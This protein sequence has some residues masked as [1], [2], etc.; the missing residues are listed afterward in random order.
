MKRNTKFIIGMATALAATGILAGCGTKKYKITFVSNGS[1]LVPTIE[2]DWGQIPTMPESPS[3]EG[4]TFAGWFTDI[5]LN[6]PYVASPVETDITL[7][8]KWTINAYNVS[9][10]TGVDGLNIPSQTLN[11]G[12]KINV[13]N[14]IRRDYYSFGGWYYDE[15]FS[16]AYNS[17][18]TVPGHDITLYAK[19]LENNFTITFDANNNAATGSMEQIKLKETDA[20]KKLPLNKF[21]VTGMEFLGWSSTPNGEVEYLDGQDLLHVRDNNDFTLYA[22]WGIKSLNVGFYALNSNDV[23][24]P[25]KNVPT[26]K[27]GEAVVAPA[28]EPT[29]AGHTFG[30]WGKM[31]PTNDR[32]ANIAKV[33]YSVLNDSYM[34]VPLNNGDDISSLGLLEVVKV[35]LSREIAT[36]ESAY[37]PVFNRIQTKIHFFESIDGVLGEEIVVKEGYYQTSLQLSDPSLTKP[38]KPGYIVGGWYYE[39]ACQ[40]LVPDTGL[41]FGE[42]DLTIYLQ[43][44]HNAH[45][46]RYSLDKGNS[47][48]EV[49]RF[50][51]DEIGLP[52]QSK[53]GYTFKGWSTS[54]ESTVIY[55][56]K[57]PDDNLEL[58]AV[59]EQKTYTVTLH[60]AA[61]EPFTQTYTYNEDL[62]LGVQSKTG[63]SFEGWYSDE[64]FKTP[65]QLTA[66][67][68]IDNLELFAKFVA[69]KH[70]ISFETNGGTSL[71]TI[72]GIE[73]GKALKDLSIATPEKTGYAFVKWVNKAGEDV[74]LETATMGDA[75]LELTAVYSAQ[76]VNVNIVF[77]GQD[78]GASTYS[79]IDEG[80]TT[81]LADQKGFSIGVDAAKAIDGYVFERSDVIDVKADGT[82]SINV[83]Y[84]RAIMKVTFT[85]NE[86]TSKEVNVTFGGKIVSVPT[87][88]DKAGYKQ[89]YKVDGKEVDLSKLVIEKDTTIAIEYVAL[90]QSIT[91]NAN[92]GTYNGKASDYAEYITD[93]EVTLPGGDVT[94]REGYTLLG[95]STSSDGLVIS[96]KYSMPANSVTLYAIWQVNEYTIDF[97]SAQG[98]APASI[99]AAYNS[100]ITLP[101]ITAD[102]Y[103]FDGYKN[104][105]DADVAPGKYVMP[106]DGDTLT[107]KWIENTVKVVFHG[108]GATT[109]SMSDQ[110]ITYSGNKAIS[111]NAFTKVGYHF[112]GWALS[113][114]G[115]VKY[116]DKAN[117]EANFDSTTATIDLYAIWAKSQFTITFDSNGGS[118]VSPITLD[119]E[120]IFDAPKA[121]TLKG[122]TFIGWFTEKDGGTI[123]Y[124]EQMGAS[125][126]TYYAHWSANKYNVVFDSNGGSPIESL[127]KTQGDQLSTADYPL[128]TPTRTGYTFDGWYEKDGTYAADGQ[129]NADW[130]TKITVDNI[131][132]LAIDGDDITLHARWII[133]KHN[134][135]YTYYENSIPKENT[136]TYNYGEAI[137]KPADPV[138]EAGQT[139]L[140]WSINNTYGTTEEPVYFDFASG[141][142]GDEDIKLYAVIS[143]DKYT[144]NFVVGDKVVCSIPSGGADPSFLSYI[145]KLYGETQALETIYDAIN[146]A[147]TYETTGGAA[148]SLSKITAVITYATVGGKTNPELYFVATEAQSSTAQAQYAYVVL[149]SIYGTPNE[150]TYYSD[151]LR[152]AGTLQSGDPTAITNLIG[153]L[154]GKASDP[155]YAQILASVKKALPAGFGGSNDS[156]DLVAL[157][158]YATIASQYSR[159]DLITMFAVSQGATQIDAASVVTTLETQFPFGENSEYY[160]LVA[161]KGASGIEAIS[162][163]TSEILTKKGEE[164]SEYE[165]NAYNPVSHAEDSYFDGWRQ[166]VDSNNHT[167]TN[168]AEFVS[169]EKS[170]E[171]ITVAARTSSS[172]TFTW[173]EVTGA[174][175]YRVEIYDLA[176]GELL[177]SDIVRTNSFKMNGLVKGDSIKVLVTTLKLGANGEYR[178]DSKTYTTQSVVDGSEITVPSSTLDSIPVEITY[179]HSVEDDIGKVSK[180][181][182]YYYITED[183]EKQQ[184]YI[185]FTNTTYGFGSRKLEIVTPG[186]GISEV[187]KSSTNADAIITHNETGDFIFTIDGVRTL[188]KVLPM[189]DIIKSGANYEHSETA[190]VQPDAKNRSNFESADYLGLV[191]D[192]Y[193]I[194][195]S[196]TAIVDGAEYNYDKDGVKYFNGFKF[197]VDSLSTTGKVIKLDIEYKFYKIE[198]GERVEITNPDKLYFYDAQN[199]VFYFKKGSGAL[200]D[201]SNLGDYVVE[202]TA[203]A[204]N[205]ANSYVNTYVPNAIKNDANKMARLKKVISFTLNEGVNVYTCD[206]LRAAMAD[207]NCSSI[208]IQSNIHGELA[209][210][211]YGYMDHLMDIPAIRQG[212]LDW[213][214]DDTKATTKGLTTGDADIKAKTAVMT[215]EDGYGPKI[216]TY[217]GTGNPAF[218]DCENKNV[219]YAGVEGGTLAIKSAEFTQNFDNGKF[220]ILA[221]L[222]HQSY[223]NTYYPFGYKTAQMFQRV[224]KGNVDLQINGNY[225]DIN[226][227]DALFCR[228]ASKNSFA[229]TLATYEI[230]SCHQMVFVNA[231]DCDVTAMNMNVISNSN[232]ASAM[233]GNDAKNVAEIMRFTSGGVS[234]FM[235]T[236]YYT[237]C[238][239]VIHL[240]SV[241]VTGS[242]IG[243]YC[244]SGLDAEYCHVKDSWANGVYAYC[245]SDAT[246]SLK[247]SVIESSGGCAVQVDDQEFTY[248]KKDGQG[249][250]IITNPTAAIDF[251]SCTIENFVSGDEQWFKGYSMEVVALGLKSMIDNQVAGYGL[252]IIKERVNPVSG[253]AGEYMNWEFF[254]RTDGIKSDKISDFPYDQAFIDSHPEDIL[255]YM[256]FGSD[257]VNSGFTVAQL[258]ASKGIDLPSEYAAFANAQVYASSDPSKLIFMLNLTGEQY[259]V[260]PTLTPVGNTQSIIVEVNVNATGFAVGNMHLFFRQNQ[261]GLGWLQ[262]M[263]QLFQK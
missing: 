204:D 102:G 185:F 81:A 63:Y 137:Q 88:F 87:D 177:K 240:S 2:I 25:M 255:T 4:Y 43:Y 262:G 243:I 128:A 203:K 61:A 104:L 199:D 107:A 239:G 178:A 32:Q 106:L 3:K 85:A 163:A 172:V 108:N 129:P 235:N 113:A 66:M 234:G 27:Y 118:N 79:T 64:E 213:E 11:Y 145:E 136:V 156:R 93:A 86:H 164:Y 181:G 10:S 110:T 92:G 72:T 251:T 210:N 50:Y 151:I 123:V 51:G 202:I 183:D 54:P 219:Y 132:T 201:V 162:N 84:T 173:D 19:W 65:F 148:G 125:N 29:L 224:G 208:N 187:G 238:D 249:N 33:Y 37:F 138:L 223:C 57:M 260:N 217:S 40:R 91:F 252:T 225:Y 218:V 116:A 62:N 167:I 20:S 230:Q 247:N 60:G 122:Y 143:E 80:T 41:I 258:A 198:N 100:E 112:T 170:V 53:T 14:D 34:R 140:G 184:T 171:D 191:K 56:G 168:Y 74:N 226:A 103:T 254:M 174:Y 96:G 8:G 127:E 231:S 13:Q 45:T 44:V 246:V 78:L 149:S 17:N 131:S 250:P 46:L 48:T 139:F 190:T 142:M 95:W 214:K 248:H 253:L 82:S 21:K 68:D 211:M 75:D 194:G 207:K 176:T 212:I 67:P 186:A 31:Q 220:K 16:R 124:P 134:V 154:T 233:L 39:L 83:Y 76:Q 188:G 9:F 141:F 49:S 133:K 147:V 120:T 261:P 146:D 121:P 35:D 227:Q 259:G 232:N 175:G 257:F 157:A 94:V 24:E 126:V 36:D 135:T 166:V 237:G 12:S 161:E 114:T 30:G 221:V 71:E 179:V 155:I 98:T 23:L 7:Y 180:S 90:P 195:A 229:G 189:P 169:R 69:H 215:T 228:S 101:P 193:K 158:T 115:E 18:D 216:F 242:L 97:V 6:N 38:A 144:I 59:F 263:V 52:T 153:E 130:G 47:F 159:E 160:N 150:A 192:S 236:D 197:D 1:T 28:T 206:G 42:T 99:T 165:N 209:P 22:I 119:Y 205:E 109:G 73:Y 15:A 111:E 182:E 196:D 117:I 245:D 244:D 241:N 55:E 105:D 26:V 222:P 256:D 5:G 200:G 77:K 58:Y 152:S 89:V 70:Q